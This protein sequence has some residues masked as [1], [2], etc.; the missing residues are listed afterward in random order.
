MCPHFADQLE[1]FVRVVLLFGSISALYGSSDFSVVP[2]ICSFSGAC[3]LRTRRW[4]WPLLKI[5]GGWTAT[6]ACYAAAAAATAGGT[7][8]E[9]FMIRT[10]G[11][12]LHRVLLCGLSRH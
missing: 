7:Q 11:L 12:I 9:T 2:L 10:H 1:I 4:L 8:S 5:C 6:A 3:F